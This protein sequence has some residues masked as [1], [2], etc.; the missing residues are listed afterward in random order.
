MSVLAAMVTLAWGCLAVLTLAM[1]GMLRQLRELQ[2]EVVAL[3]ADQGMKPWRATVGRR[4][5]QLAGTGPAVLLVLDPGCGL[6]DE[7]HQPFTRLPAEYPGIRFEVLSPRALRQHWTEAA[8]IRSR[9]DAALVAELDL[10]WAPA[11]LHVAAD[12]TV[13]AMQPVAAAQQ[14]DQHVAGLLNTAMV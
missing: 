3:R 11:L 8:N 14:I 5:P 9:V 7:V 2:T 13:L 6:C 4:M 10:P 12:G 1:A